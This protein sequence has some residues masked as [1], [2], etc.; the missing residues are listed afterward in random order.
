MKLFILLIGLTI[1]LTGCVFTDSFLDEKVIVEITSSYQNI[2]EEITILQTQLGLTY[3]SGATTTANQEYTKEQLENAKITRNKLEVSLSNLDKQI[4]EL[5]EEELR[6]KLESSITL[7][8]E[9]LVI[10]EKYSEN[11]YYY[12]DYSENYDT[13]EKDFLAARKLDE[14]A[15]KA[16]YYD[17]NYDR[18]KQYLLDAKDKTDK[19]KTDLHQAQEIMVLDT[20]KR[21]DEALSH[22]S[23]YLELSLDYVEL[24]DEEEYSKADEVYGELIDE[25]E[26]YYDL[27]PND[28][29]VEEEEQDWILNNLTKVIGK[30]E[31][32]R[33]SA[34]KVFGD[35]LE[36][37]TKK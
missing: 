10:E 11:Y 33:L 17:E 12:L 14:K 32:K 16:I 23:I 22:F 2:Q 18:A 28:T 36:E 9:Y 1:F 5:K 7:Y 19:A 15:D 24:L 37:S 29:E 13:F 35:A 21:F 27:L 3:A 4:Q 26:A 25:Y 6:E 20:D 34:H 30:A 31:E 8:K